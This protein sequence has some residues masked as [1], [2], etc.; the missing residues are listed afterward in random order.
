[1]L[2]LGRFQRGRIVFEP[3]ISQLIDPTG[4]IVGNLCEFIPTNRN[5]E[6]NV[7]RFRRDDCFFIQGSWDTETYAVK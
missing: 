1:M 5:D 2:S 6:N 4:G 3:L 7:A